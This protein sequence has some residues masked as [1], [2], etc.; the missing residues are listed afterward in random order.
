MNL[1]IE[2]IQLHGKPNFHT[3]I[4]LA[5]AWHTEILSVLDGKVVFAGVLGGY[6]NCVKIEHTYKDETIY[7][8]YAH[9]AEIYVHNGQ[10]VKQGNV[11]GT[12]GG[13]PNKDNNPGSSTGSHLHFEIRKS[14]NGDFQN[15]RNY[16]YG[17]GSS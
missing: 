11:I 4:D 3:G 15:P 1:E 14:I 6:G 2:Y 16:L 5:G 12:Q 13:D 17:G 8:L 9:L 7:S 10:D